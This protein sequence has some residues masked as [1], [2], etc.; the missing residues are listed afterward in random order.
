MTDLIRR[1]AIALGT[2]VSVAT[3]GNVSADENQE[4]LFEIEFALGKTVYSC[5][6]RFEDQY[7]GPFSPHCIRLSEAGGPS[8][9]AFGV[10]DEKWFYTRE[11]KKRNGGIFFSYLSY[12]KYTQKSFKKPKPINQSIEEYCSNLMSLCVYRNSE[13]VRRFREGLPPTRE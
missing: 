3:V 7:G 8:V 5:V 10:E 2:L 4:R 1:T 13:D 9:L 12:N 11:N 6:E